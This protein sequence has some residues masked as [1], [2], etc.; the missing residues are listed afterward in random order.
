MR[1]LGSLALLLLLPTVASAQKAATTTALSSNSP[2]LQLPGTLTLSATVAGSAGAAGQP[3]GPVSFVSDSSSA[4][5]S[6]T[7]ATIPST[8]A[9]SSTGVSGSFGNSPFGLFTLAP[10]TSKDSVLGMLDYFP[11]VSSDSVF[12]QFTIFSGAGAALFQSSAPYQITNSGYSAYGSVTAYAVADFNHD[13]IPDILLYGT[14]ANTGTVPVSGSN[15][16][17]IYV[18]PGKAGG[19][20]NQAA[21]IFSPD[22][23]GIICDCTYPSAALAVDDFNGD[24]YPDLAYAANGSFSNNLVGVALNAGSSDPGS[25]QRFITAPAPS[26]TG[27]SFQTQAIASGH[28]TSSGHADLIVAGELISTTTGTVDDAGDLAIY[29][30]NGD[31]TF[32]APALVRSE[33]VTPIAVATADFRRNGMTDVVVANQGTET[34]SASVVV[35]FGDGNGN[36]SVSSTV[37]LTAAPVTLNVA[38]FNNDGYPDIV[39]SDSGGALQLLLND[40]TGHFS[41]ATSIGTPLAGSSLLAVGDFNGDSLEDVVQLGRGASESPT[42]S[43]LELL[44]S[45]SALATVNTPAQSL[46][47][48]AHTL[49]AS[50]PGDANFTASS[51]NLGVTVTQTVPTITWPAPA[52]VQ[53]GAALG[54]AQLD[55]TA[56]VPGSFT[57]TPGAGTVLPAGADTVK[58]V[59]APTDS[60]DYS[61]ATASQTVTVINGNATAQVSAP[62]TVGAGQNSSVTLTVSPYPSPIT[63]TLTLSFAPDPPNTVSDPAVLFPNNSNT[64][65]IQIPANSSAAIPP[66]AFSPG[67]TAGKIT[68]TVQLT[69]GGANITPSGLAPAVVTVPAGPPVIN[70]VTLTRNGRQMTVAILGLSSTRDMT[71][72]S[73]QFTPAAGHSLTTTQFTVPLSTEFSGW[74]ST[75]DSANYGTM[76]LYTQPFTLDSDASSVGN[77]TVTLTNSQGQSQ[78]GTA[79]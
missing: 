8:E 3:T 75:S 22:N 39:I 54:T 73:F 74:Y 13:G 61:G 68:I 12:P 21:A 41:K 17:E 28:F 16:N 33:G 25:F 23:S 78:P 11:I 7:L 55:A 37:S 44:N 66:I 64:D 10:T 76:F 47:A 20:Y 72:A 36:L 60:F 14:P 49:T 26:L 9:F 57:Y 53:L 56:S 35:L 43:E 52:A 77:V 34:G 1:R 59:F 65:V 46:P 58:A 45:A 31:G 50:F 70:S 27:D 24:G 62:A 63:A 30:G 6:G 71:Q 38:D 18:L 15:G 19:T 67:S 69:S 40:G 29:L 48:G 2:G 79:Q 51:S 4:L 5:G 42:S 32:A